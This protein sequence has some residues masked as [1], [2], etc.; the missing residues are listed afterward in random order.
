MNKHEAAALSEL[1]EGL[2]EYNRG[3]LTALGHGKLFDD[4][5]SACVGLEIVVHRVRDAEAAATPEHQVGNLL[6]F[7]EIDEVLVQQH[8][9]ALRRVRLAWEP[10]DTLRRQALQ[11]RDAG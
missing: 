11:M 9:D 6:F 1:A 10:I 2:H 8:R 4:W 3:V 5:S 7:P